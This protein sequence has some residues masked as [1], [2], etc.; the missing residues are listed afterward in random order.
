MM[1]DSKPSP[2]QPSPKLAKMLSEATPEQRAEALKVTA[3][4]LATRAK[5][6]TPPKG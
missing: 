5:M 4:L 2:A 1:Q 3:K 6:Q